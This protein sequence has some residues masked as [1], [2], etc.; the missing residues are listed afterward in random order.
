MSNITNVVVKVYLAVNNAGSGT[1]TTYWRAVYRWPK[2][3]AGYIVYWDED[4]DSGPSQKCRVYHVGVT[5]P[6]G[7][8]MYWTLFSGHFSYNQQTGLPW[9][10][11]SE[12]VDNY[13]WG[14][15][16]QAKGVATGSEARCGQMW[17]EVS[18]DDSTTR[19]IIPQD[20]DSHPYMT[21]DPGGNGD[22]F[23]DTYD[24]YTVADTMWGCDIT[25]GSNFYEMAQVGTPILRGMFVRGNEIQVV[26]GTQY[27]PIATGVG[28][29]SPDFGKT[30]YDLEQ[31]PSTA[32][33]VVFDKNDPTHSVVGCSGQLVV[34]DSG[35]TDY[36]YASGASIIGQATRMD[37][38]LNS[39]V[40][41]IGTTEAV[42][43]TIDWGQTAY[44]WLNQPAPAGVALG[45][46]SLAISG[47]E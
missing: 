45:G 22:D 20:E 4:G 29:R 15:Y 6:P 46:S 2:T 16:L 30:W 7:D 26:G 5:S 36:T 35:D 40:V 34:Y 33:D 17:L 44:K 8:V 18:Y 27:A 28:K 19:Y 3:G 21:E 32:G 10:S 25:G 13:R 1:R 37:A 41:V 24:H 38:D 31:L 39:D 9:A 11:L 14:Y 12:I 23:P 47:E 42:Y 43:K